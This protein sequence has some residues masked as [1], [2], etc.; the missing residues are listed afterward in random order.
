METIYVNKRGNGARLNT[1]TF[2]LPLNTMHSMVNGEVKKVMYEI[3]GYRLKGIKDQ[4]K[5]ITSSE[6]DTKYDAKSKSFVESD[7]PYYKAKI[8]YTWKKK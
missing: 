4:L 5:S 7:N 1:Y 6:K 3:T 8:V 2:K